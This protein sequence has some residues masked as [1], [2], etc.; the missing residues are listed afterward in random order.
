MATDPYKA[1]DAELEID[2]DLPPRPVRGIAFGLIIDIGGT[3]LVTFIATIIYGFLLIS[4]GA[5]QTE[6]QNLVSNMGPTTL[7]GFINA[8]LGTLM[9]F[10]GGFYCAK[11]SRARNY[12]Y[13]GI[14][15]SISV[16][17]GLVFGW[18]TMGIMLLVVFSMTTAAAVL[19]GA[20]TWLKR[21]S[22]PANASLR[23]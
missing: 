14:M 5:S 2:R 22:R 8:V 10:V 17:L 21:S 6:I 18:N 3:I 19:L 7:F 16:V 4:G 11:I 23:A 1:P 9:S 20:R 12:R 13:P 15:A